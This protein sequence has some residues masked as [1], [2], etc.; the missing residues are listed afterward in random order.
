[1]KDLYE[2]YG[3]IR[4]RSYNIRTEPVN[5]IITDRVLVL[6]LIENNEV[7]DSRTFPDKS[8][9]YYESAGENWMTGVLS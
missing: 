2:R 1:M 6:D 5:D 9:Y 8:Y 7:V 4:N 3:L